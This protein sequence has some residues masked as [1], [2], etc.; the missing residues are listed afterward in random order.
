MIPLNS[1]ALIYSNI[2]DYLY[3]DC[4]QSG[5]RCSETIDKNSARARVRT[6]TFAE[7]MGI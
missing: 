6:L 7:V 2:C 1:D 3:Y 5:V 4:M